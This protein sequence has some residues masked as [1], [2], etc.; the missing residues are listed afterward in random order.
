M[1]YHESCVQHPTA[2]SPFVLCKPHGLRIKKCKECSKKLN[3]QEQQRQ[4]LLPAML[5]TT[6]D[7]NWGT[8]AVTQHQADGDG[9]LSALMPELEQ[10]NFDSVFGLSDN[11]AAPLAIGNP[12]PVTVCYTD[13]NDKIHMRYSRWFAPPAMTLQ[14]KNALEKELESNGAENLMCFEARGGKWLVRYELTR[15]MVL[16]LPAMNSIQPA[17]L[18]EPEHHV[19]TYARRRK[20][21]IMK[22]AS[23]ISGCPK[24]V[25]IVALSTLGLDGERPFKHAYANTA[26]VR[27]MLARE[28]IIMFVRRHLRRKRLHQIAGHLRKA[29]ADAGFVPWLKDTHMLARVLTAAKTLRNGISNG[30]FSPVTPEGRMKRK[31]TAMDELT[32]Y[33]ATRT[34]NVVHNDIYQAAIVGNPF[35]LFPSFEGLS[36]NRPIRYTLF[37]KCGND[38]AWR[39][40]LRTGHMCRER[41]FSAKIKLLAV[42]SLGGQRHMVHGFNAD[43][44]E[45][46]FEPK[47]DITRLQHRLTFISRTDAQPPCIVR[48]Q[49]GK[50]DLALQ[51]YPR[52]CPPDTSVSQV[53]LDLAEASNSGPLP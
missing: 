38:K 45:L 18:E 28:Q 31:R 5:P 25:E 29:L 33:Q 2:D 16:R 47:T 19:D 17:P 44:T 52:M 27:V 22:M 14:K 32:L 46:M 9:L 35:R 43:R 51:V 13:D 50:I 23:Y 20:N 4:E 48:L 39:V 53:V 26:A 42:F 24:P 49:N 6:D 7:L 34:G 30:V 40:T 12:P 15:T 10:E 21:S 8:F 11:D 1:L 3:A 36:M 37:P 41:P